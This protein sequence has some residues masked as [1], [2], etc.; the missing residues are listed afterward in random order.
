MINIMILE[1][2]LGKDPVLK[3]D[4]G[5]NPQF[6]TF[7]MAQTIKRKVKGEEQELTIWAEVTIWGKIAESH[8][9]NLHKGRRVIVNGSMLIEDWVDRDNKN[10][11]TMKIK[12]LE[13]NYADEPSRRN[14]DNDSEEAPATSVDKLYDETP[15]TSGAN[16]GTPW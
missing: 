6:C 15:L 10:R 4:S 1:G 2:H 12:A 13:V 14:N 9:K 11:Y 8:A 16:N 5:G 7:T 3:R